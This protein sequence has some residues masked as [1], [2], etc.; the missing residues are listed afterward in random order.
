MKQ[1]KGEQLDKLRIYEHFIETVVEHSDE[2]QEISNVTDRAANS[3]G[4][5]GPTRPLGTIEDP[6]EDPL[7]PPHIGKVP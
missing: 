1:N 2:Y 7:D 3:R 4:P 5:R 6:I